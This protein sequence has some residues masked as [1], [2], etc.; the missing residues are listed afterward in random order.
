MLIHF[1]GRYRNYC[2]G[3]QLRLRPAQ[4]QNQ[5]RLSV[6]NRRSRQVAGVKSGDASWAVAR[7]QAPILL[8]E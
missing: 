4:E 3:A 8:E 7:I 5:V 6:R 2:H 1:A